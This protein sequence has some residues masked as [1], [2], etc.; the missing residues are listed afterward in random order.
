MAEM[1]PVE[2][3]HWAIAKVKNVYPDIVFIAEV[4]NPAQYR[5]Y[6]HYGGFDYLYDKVGMYDTLRSVVQGQGTAE[7][8]TYAW[9]AVDDIKDHMLNFMENHDEQRIASQFFADDALKGFPAMAVTTLISSSPVMVYAGQELGEDAH[10]AEGFSGFDGR[11]T[12]FDYW[13]VES[14]CK[15]QKI[16]EVRSEELG[17][18]SDLEL[19]TFNSQLSTLNLYRRLIGVANSEV[20][21]EGK[22][23]DLMWLNQRNP[24]FDSFRQYAF[25]RYTDK[26]VLLVVANFAG[27]ERNVRLNLTHHLFEAM[28][29]EAFGRVVAQD[30][31]TDIT[32]ELN[33]SADEPVE[34]V[35]K[36]YQVCAYLI[37]W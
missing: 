22:F 30:L 18:R 7:A 29:R 14:L 13:K 3:W 16:F 11:T 1:V 19:S 28:G 2:F 15:L 20:V 21:A 32:A 31:M 10:E 36:P 9:Q 12:I 34:I 37:K 25:V 26:E 17:V 4:Y 6:I 27:E 35:L 8:I 23:Y 24:Q 5:S 33:F